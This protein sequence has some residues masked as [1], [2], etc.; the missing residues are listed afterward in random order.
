MERTEE[1]KKYISGFF[2]G[3]A[4]IGIEKQN[5]TGYCLRI[6]FCQSNK[7]TL[8]TFQK[9]YPFM[10]LDGGARRDNCKNEY[11]L[12]AAGKQ[13]E[14]LIDDL[15]E[16]SILKYEQLLEA[17]KF[18]KLINVIGKTDEKEIIYNNLKDL[19]KNSKNKPYNRLCKE[20]I[21][22]LFD[23]EGS[24]GIYNN[25]LRVKTTQKSD[26]L[27]L[28][29]IGKMYNNINKIDNYAISFYGVNCKDFLNDVLPFCIYKTPQ[30]VAALKYI[31]T[32]NCEITDEIKKERNKYIDSIKNEK[33]IDI[34]KSEKDQDNDK[35][36]LR[37][38]FDEFSKKS[39]EE[40]IGYCKKL[41]IDKLKNMTKFENKIYNID[42]W[43][44]FNINPVLE[45]CE[46]NNQL[47]M[48]QY[49]RKV[50]SSLPSTGVIGR[51]IRILVKDTI[52]NKYIGILCISSDVYNLGER[53]KYI[54]KTSRN[55]EWKEKYLKNIMNISCCVPFQPF[56][57][58]TTGG[59]L[60][61]SLAFSKEVFDYYYKKYNEPLL[62]LIT[63]SINGKSIQYDRLLNLRMIGYTKGFGSVNIPEDFY[64]ICKEYNNTWKVIEKNNRI[65]RFD[66]LK[67]LLTHLELPQNILQH[68][69]K[70]GIYFGYLFS[71][72]L[73]DNYDTS[74]LRTVEQIYLWWKT[75][76]CNNRI[77][78]LKNKKLLKTNVELYTS[79]YFKN[80][81]VKFSFE[82][83]QIQQPK[84][85]TVS[86]KL[87]T[88][89][90][91]LEIKK[92]QPG[93]IEKL[94][95]EQ[96][97]TIIR[98]KGESKTTQQVSDYIKSNFNV[99]IK[100]DFISKI[101]NDKVPELLPEE[102]KKTKEY[103]DMLNNKKLRTVKTVSYTH[104]R[105][106][107]T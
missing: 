98:M 51:A 93:I 20:Y 43:E 38:C 78:N 79:D 65:D 66:F 33:Y 105:A 42:N 85:E 6:K 22:G 7:N 16:F 69:N 52:S 35:E 100:R 11:Q 15:L 26:T 70:R 46:T 104:L 63:T 36:Y 10:K 24:I 2:D 50:V 54:T 57:Y 96:L 106:H 29:N 97:L 92:Q 9:Y 14:P 30:I 102:I 49:Y 103:T 91:K 31:D 47:Q 88:K 61:A 82:K 90:P 48:Y 1:F 32:L 72:I 87:E 56:G 58:N 67:R 45:F 53:D 55:L 62:G 74:E 64:N 95:N 12:R 39:Y 77:N 60:L 25:S 40:V 94:N 44:D 107:E 27:I 13:I 17:K 18:I 89:A 86:P 68:N 71:T 41:E 21:A 84:L 37:R 73:N 8:I 4:S 19:K 23:A 76:W 80:N 75:R 101:W 3:D 34:D 5:K 99:Y 83:L 59:K 28:E 81:S